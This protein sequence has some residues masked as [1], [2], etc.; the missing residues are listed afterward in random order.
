[1]SLL[2]YSWLLWSLEAYCVG[3]LEASIIIVCRSMEVHRS[4][5]SNMF[6]WNAANWPFAHMTFNSETTSIGLHTLRVQNLGSG[7]SA[8]PVDMATKRV[9]SDTRFTFLGSDLYSSAY[10]KPKV[11]R[12]ISIA[13]SVIGILDNV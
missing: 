10:C 12:R 8:S 6:T 2:L 13:S 1:M 3:Y 11:L 9:E 5:L 4:H 7:P